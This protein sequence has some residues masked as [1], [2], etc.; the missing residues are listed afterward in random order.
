MGLDMYAN[1]F[2]G[3][4]KSDV[5]FKVPKTTEEFHYWR[6]HQSLHQWMEQLYQNKGGSDE[7]NSGN[8]VL[9]T[10]EDLDSLEYKIRKGE[11]PE[12]SGFFLTENDDD[13]EFISEAREAISNGYQVYYTS[14]W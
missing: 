12:T 7:F 13:L 2:K 6:K 9:L 14:W 3:K 11:L 8:N 5:D 1:K 4:V 10:E